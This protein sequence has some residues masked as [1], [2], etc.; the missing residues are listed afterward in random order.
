MN[1]N[2]RDCMGAH[3]LLSGIN[4]VS[5]MPKNFAEM[6]DKKSKDAMLKLKVVVESEY[7]KDLPETK[8]IKS[9]V[10]ENYR[11]V[12]NKTLESAVRLLNKYEM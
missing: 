3:D 10:V 7:F 5:L 11:W 12:K 1:F 4:E 6:Q 8:I 2:V 9:G